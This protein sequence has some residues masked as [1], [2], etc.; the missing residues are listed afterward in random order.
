MDRF[1]QKV[2]L[3][4][5]IPSSVSIWGQIE[6]LKALV[7]SVVDDLASDISVHESIK[8]TGNSTV[9]P[10]G[11]RDVISVK[12]DMPFQGNRQVKKTYDVATRTVWLRYFPA[13]IRYRRDFTVEDLDKAKGDILIYIKSYLFWKMADKELTIIT[14]VKLDADNGEVNTD[15]LRSFLETNKARYENLKEGILLYVN[16]N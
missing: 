15:D 8:A 16:S 6:D 4:Y 3:E 7:E 12:L 9:L 11:A 13:V 14:S 2:W 10:E 1:L 5:P